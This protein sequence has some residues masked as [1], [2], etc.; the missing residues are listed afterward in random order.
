MAEI[1]Y[2]DRENMPY[3]LV[4]MMTKS[5]AKT[6]IDRGWW[7]DYYVPIQEILLQEGKTL[8]LASGD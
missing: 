1:L 7:H 3:G 5:H 6:E 8:A 4:I 2:N